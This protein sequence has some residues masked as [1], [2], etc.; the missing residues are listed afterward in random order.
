MLAHR[1]ALLFLQSAGSTE[2]AEKKPHGMVTA[3]KNFQMGWYDLSALVSTQPGVLKA[4]EIEQAILEDVRGPMLEV[5]RPR[6]A[7]RL[8]TDRLSGR[9]CAEC[10]GQ[11]ARERKAEADRLRAEGD[12]EAQVFAT[13]LW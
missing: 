10:F 2:V 5:R 13:T 6:R 3:A 4:G 7:D 1:K 8:Q 11:Y 12:R 9:E